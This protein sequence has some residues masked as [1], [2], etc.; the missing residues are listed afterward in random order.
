MGGGGEGKK[1]GGVKAIS[2]W[3]E[4][5]G[6]GGGGQAFFRDAVID[7]LWCPRIVMY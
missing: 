7:H 3:P 6:G 5:G 1:R 2:D 4:V